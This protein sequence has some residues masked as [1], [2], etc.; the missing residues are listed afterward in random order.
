MVQN[1]E[2]VRRSRGRPQVRS[3]EETLRVLIDAA[4]KEFPAN[5]YAGTS[6][7]AVALAA[8]VST[9]T[10]YRL[11]ATKAEL[12][13][14]VVTDRIGRFMLTFDDS[15]SDGVDP[16]AGLERILIAYG[17]LTLA[18]E[19]I[20]IN[21]LVIGE[22]DRFPEIAAMFYEKAILP[23][24]DAIAAWL[25]RQCARGLIRLADPQRAAGMLR[26]M[27]I[28]EPQRAA[29]LGRRAAPDEREIAERAKACAELFLSGCR[30]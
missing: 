4:A 11:I 21:R 22:C 6:I 17:T 14:L 29:T 19:T 16:A 7:G 26:G 5:G 2:M 9:K 30:R 15:A 28:M 18:D 1:S 8:G 10:L 3:D 20:A 24:G 12:F 25:T 27:M 13:G 23:T